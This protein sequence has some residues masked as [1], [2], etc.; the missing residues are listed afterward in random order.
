MPIARSTT[1]SVV[2]EESQ[3]DTPHTLQIAL[4]ESWDAYSPHVALSEVETILVPFFKNHHWTLGVVNLEACTIGIV[5]SYGGPNLAHYATLGHFAQ[6][7]IPAGRTRYTWVDV[8][9]PSTPQLN[10]YDCGAFAICNA[11]LILRRLT[12]TA[13]FA[14]TMAGYRRRIGHRLHSVGYR[15]RII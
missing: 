12:L 8:L 3:I 7:C 9:M 11:E 5:D 6:T 15:T 14:S 4:R 10:G 1:G 2:L 13:R